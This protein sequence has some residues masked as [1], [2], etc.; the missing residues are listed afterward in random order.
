[1]K[2]DFE[3][4]L[5]D[6][7]QQDA[8]IRE[9]LHALYSSPLSDTLYW[10]L[11]N[12]SLVHNGYYKLFYYEQAVLK[13]IILFE[14]VAKSGRIL[15]L[16]RHYHISETEIRNI[17]SILF[18]E[19]DKVQQIIFKKIY[20]S[21]YRQSSKIIF[22]KSSNDVIIEL[23]ES[24][25]TYM[26][27]LG[28]S[29]RERFRQNTKRIVRDFPDFQFHYL[30]KDD[31]LFEDIEKVILLH[32]GRM[33]TKGITISGDEKL[34]DEAKYAT[35][36]DCGFLCVCTIN[37]KIIGGAINFIVGEHAYLF[38]IGHNDSYNYYSVGQLVLANTIKYLIEEKKIKH[39][40]LSWGKQ[41]YKFKYGGINHEIYT[42]QVFRNFRGKLKTIFKQRV[43]DNKILYNFYLK[44]KNNLII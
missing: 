4:E 36:S 21:N 39:Y 9:K 16:N 25:D 15:V 27:S 11:S 30:E 7:N 5:L 28:K 2:N 14:Y 26:K 32:R 8:A 35:T 24:F 33:K 17:C 19:F 43:K 42:L 29:T 1:M 23:P 40:H 41:D 6:Q 3:Y 18:R 44:F 38:V 31:I 22:E 10:E 34:C 37:D 13:Q 12:P 20:F